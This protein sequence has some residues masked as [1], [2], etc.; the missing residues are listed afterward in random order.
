MLYFNSHMSRDLLDL[1]TL[2]NLPFWFAQYRDAMDFEYKVDFW[3]Y[4]ETG[5][6]PGIEGK[7]DINLMFLY[8]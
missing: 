8:E 1:K 4:T 2:R 6:V 5:T 7:V 3:Q